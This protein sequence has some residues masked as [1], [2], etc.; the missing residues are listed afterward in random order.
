MT[1]FEELKT[2]VLTATAG[3]TEALGFRLAQA[4]PENV[5]IALSG[6]LGCGKTTLVRGIA[7]GLGI[8]RAV[9]SPTYNIYTIYRG[10]RQLVHMDAYRLSDA[11]EL[12]SLGI[13]EL[14][15]SPFL[16][17]VEWPEHVP[18]FLEDFP[19][20]PIRLEIMEDHRHEIRLGFIPEEQT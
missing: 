11:H 13:G 1:V 10:T 2:G 16:I 3:E 9:T 5:A 17:V 14:L 12:D 8:E 19:V 7:R 6:D 15:A 20:W 4:L 18:G